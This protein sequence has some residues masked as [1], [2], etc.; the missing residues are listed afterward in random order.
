M[1][2]R[3]ADEIVKWERPAMRDGPK[4]APLFREVE[5]D[6]IW[7]TEEAAEHLINE[8]KKKIGKEDA[9]RYDFLH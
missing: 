7:G 8:S 3:Q 6:G 9:R 2:L 1:G 4:G 5:E